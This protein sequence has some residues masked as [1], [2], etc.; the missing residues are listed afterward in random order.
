MTATRPKKSAQRHTA[1]RSAV[2]DCMADGVCAE[3]VVARLALHL[4][5]AVDAAELAEIARDMVPLDSRD[6]ERLQ[7]VAGLLRRKPGVFATLRATGAAVRHARDDE[8]TDAAVVMRLASSFD[9][10]AAISEIASVQL[11]SLGDEDRLS[12][13]TEEVAAW[14]K[15]QDFTGTGR[16]ILDIGCGIGRF[17]LALSKSFNRMVGI[18]ISSRMISI[19]SERCAALGNVDL[20]QT[21]GLDL[22]E[23]DDSSFDCV[24]AVDSFPYL[25]LAGMAERHFDEI[26]RVLKRRGWLALLNYSYRGS[27]FLDRADVSRLAEAHQLRVVINGEK[28]FRS[29]DGDAFLLARGDGTLPRAASSGV[30]PEALESATDPKEDI[31]ASGREKH[32]G[33]GS[34]GKGT[35]A[36]A[37]TNDQGQDR[38]KRGSVRS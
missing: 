12:T 8:E 34:Q 27:L 19:A 38:G 16:N 7:E 32:S 9:T 10:A 15:E 28:P 20:R 21:S 18:D 6:A 2:E 35:G 4:P 30:E 33:L 3:A 31:M 22:T 26:A 17:E 23:F 11:A 24:L 5:T 14:L 29:W 36:G 1:I 37:I 25:V 13:T